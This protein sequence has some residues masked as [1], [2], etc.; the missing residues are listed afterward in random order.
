MALRTSAIVRAPSCEQ[1]RLHLG[2]ATRNAMVERLA[3][4]PSRT[5]AR[6]F[7]FQMERNYSNS[8]LQSMARNSSY[9]Q[10]AWLDVAYPYPANH[11]HLDLRSAEALKPANPD[12][13]KGSL[14]SVE[15]VDRSSLLIAELQLS[16]RVALS[17][18]NYT[19]ISTLQ[20]CSFAQLIVLFRRRTNKQ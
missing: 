4:N 17:H 19:Q 6:N 7:L 10:D 5:A 3:R 14:A 12:S 8:N 15:Y 16:T 11:H 1:C 9:A 13:S 20:A 2:V 18:R